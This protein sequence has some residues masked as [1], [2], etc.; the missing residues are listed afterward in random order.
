MR[1]PFFGED[2]WELASGM[3]F[4]SELLAFLRSSVTLAEDSRA[5]S[6]TFGELG[7]EELLLKL[8]F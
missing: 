7:L 6:F 4:F 8:G 1:N 3:G 2:F 5:Y